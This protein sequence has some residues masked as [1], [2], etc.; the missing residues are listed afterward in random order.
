MQYSSR[1]PDFQAAISGIKCHIVESCTSTEARQ[2]SFQLEVCDSWLDCLRFPSSY[3]ARSGP[4]YSNSEME[5]RVSVGSTITEERVIIDWRLDN[6]NQVN[7]LD[8]SPKI[9]KRHYAIISE[10][11]NKQNIIIIY[12][13]IFSTY[14]NNRPTLTIDMW[15]VYRS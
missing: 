5:M 10:V 9:I 6:W 11:W 4:V 13:Y 12:C 8:R 14:Y 15:R 3:V 1:M 2:L 7:L